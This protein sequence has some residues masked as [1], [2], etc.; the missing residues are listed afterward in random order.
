MSGSMD[1][2][3]PKGRLGEFLVKVQ[4]TRTAEAKEWRE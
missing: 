2:G 3:L 1:V 4:K